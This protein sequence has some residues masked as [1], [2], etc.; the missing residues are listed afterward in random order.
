MGGTMGNPLFNMLGGGMPQNPMN[1]MLQDYKKFRQEMQGKNP[2]E[3]INKMLQSGK[4]NQNQLNQ[5]QQK[6]QQ[7]Q[8]LFKGLF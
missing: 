3:E 2:Q 6:A 1:K 8:G 7:M 5:I 4:L